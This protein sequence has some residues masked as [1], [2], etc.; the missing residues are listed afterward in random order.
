MKIVLIVLAALVGLVVLMAVIGAFLPRAHVASRTKRLAAPPE[1]VWGL[2]RDLSP[3]TSWRKDVTKIEVLPRE[4]GRER[5]RE[6]GKHGAVLYKVVEEIS[7][8]KLV[9]RIADDS[10]PYGGSWTF[11]LSPRDGGTE[12]TIT[13]DGFVKNWLFRFLSRF[14]F[15]ESA[16]IESYLD[17][18]ERELQRAQ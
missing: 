7:P 9:T 17:A 6:H 12:I 10:L 8:R 16:T 18:L 5:F 15:S 4:N 1:R 2:I 14:V 3:A 13:E 11:D